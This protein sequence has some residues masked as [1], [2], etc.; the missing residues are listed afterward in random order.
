MPIAARRSLLSGPRLPLVP[1]STLRYLPYLRY[2]HLFFVLL[3]K[4]L[5]IS[6]MSGLEPLAAFGLA[7]SVFQ[8]ISFTREV[9]KA[10]NKI[11]H[12]EAPDPNLSNNV[13][14]LLKFF[15]SISAATN[16]ASNSLTENDRAMLDIATEC[17]TTA[18]EMK[19]QADA[20]S[21]GQGSGWRSLRASLKYQFKLKS[22]VAGLE[23]RM[24]DQQSLLESRL[25]GNIW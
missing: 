15:D 14:H 8:T 12:G 19:A 16:A 4:S 22:R 9:Y 5:L 17:K 3:N 11:F 7:C 25:L 20:L 21:G 10:C 6:N 13:N 24:K 18:L 1:T 2:D 23:K